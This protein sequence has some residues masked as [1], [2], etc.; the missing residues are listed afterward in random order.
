MADALTDRGE[1]RVHTLLL[2]IN[3]L[4]HNYQIHIGD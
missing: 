2:F 1:P 4:I 3:V